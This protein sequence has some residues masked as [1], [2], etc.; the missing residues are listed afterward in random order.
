[1]DVG[2]I[3]FGFFNL[4]LEFLHGSGVTLDVFA[5]L[6]LEDFNK[7]FGQALI[8]VFTTEMSVTSSC[9]DFENSI[10]NSKE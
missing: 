3:S 1:M 10:I 5:M 2:E 4:T 6:L 7:M 8:K 9:C